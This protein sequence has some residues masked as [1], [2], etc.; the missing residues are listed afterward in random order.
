M[1]DPDAFIIK[2]QGGYGSPDKISW[3]FLRNRL[4]EAVENG[5]HSDEMSYKYFMF[6]PYEDGRDFA[7]SP[8]RLNSGE[9]ISFFL[10]LVIDGAI[11][12]PRHAYIFFDRGQMMDAWE[13]LKS[14]E[15]GEIIE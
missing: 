10:L 13:D 12:T 2:N 9:W 6:D 5:L 8:D 14:L 1:S 4:K 3:T 15:S 11:L 7:Q